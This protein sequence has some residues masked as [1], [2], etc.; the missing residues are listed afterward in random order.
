VR[1]YQKHPLTLP[2]GKQALLTT[3]VEKGRPITE[4][5]GNFLIEKG[6]KKKKKRKTLVLFLLMREGKK[7]QICVAGTFKAFSSA[8][9]PSRWSS[10][11]VNS[12]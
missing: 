7:T 8:C 6:G 5:S 11:C 12:T 4:T 9:K 2:N 10:S 3:P 1:H